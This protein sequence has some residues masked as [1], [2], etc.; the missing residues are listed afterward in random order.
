MRHYADKHTHC[1]LECVCV[2]R[3]R[4]AGHEGVL[5]VALAA[6]VGCRESQGMFA[7]GVPSRHSINTRTNTAAVSTGNARYKGT[8][9]ALTVVAR[10]CEGSKPLG[11][12]GPS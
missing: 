5:A 8:S 6:S 2:R 1:S 3:V 11:E 4:T 7:R 12:P 10:A 9:R